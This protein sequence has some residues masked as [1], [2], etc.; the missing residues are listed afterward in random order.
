MI[1][2]ESLLLVFENYFQAY[3]SK[4]K[5]SEDGKVYYLFSKSAY[6]S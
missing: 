5:R 6:Y 3:Y 2:S 1:N 4:K